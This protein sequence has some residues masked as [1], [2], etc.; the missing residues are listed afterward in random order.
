MDEIEPRH[1]A[2]GKLAFERYVESLNGIAP[3]GRGL[4]PWEALTPPEQRAWH[5]AA[6]AV[7]DIRV[8]LIDEQVLNAYHEGWKAAHGDG[9]GGDVIG[10]GRRA[11]L[12]AAAT[13]A[14]FRVVQA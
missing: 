2:L 1:T 7:L 13:L 5:D 10:Q 3:N 4:P 12:A 11:G 14:G 6:R 8:F 9:S